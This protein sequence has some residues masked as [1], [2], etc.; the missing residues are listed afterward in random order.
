[1]S[2]TAVTDKFSTDR[3]TMLESGDPANGRST[4]CYV[5]VVQYPADPL[6]PHVSVTQGSG[7]TSS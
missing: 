4:L 3:S 1:M 5:E 7:P 2:M 6:A